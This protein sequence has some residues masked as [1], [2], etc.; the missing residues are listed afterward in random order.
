MKERVPTR[1]QAPEFY[2]IKDGCR[3]SLNRIREQHQ[4]YPEANSISLLHKLVTKGDVIGQHT[5]YNHY[6]VSD[7]YFMEAE[8]SIK[9]DKL[10]L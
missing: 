10:P 1:N 2:K 7:I 9:V 5:F 3:A 4:M 6:G 8:A